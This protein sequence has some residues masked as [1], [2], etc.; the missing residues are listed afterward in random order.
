MRAREVD[1]ESKM[2][3][4]VFRGKGNSSAITDKD[5]NHLPP[6]WGPWRVTTIAYELE[7]NG[8]RYLV[9]GY[10]ATEAEIFDKIDRGE[11]YVYGSD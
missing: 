11:P 5:E 6:E 9:G 7:R 8:V 3:V 1:R 2:K 10:G 4:R